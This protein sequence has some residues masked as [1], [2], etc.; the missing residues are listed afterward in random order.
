MNSILGK[1]HYIRYLIKV[2][3]EKNLIYLPPDM[4]NDFSKPALL[5]FLLKHP[6]SILIIEDA[7]NIVRDR[8]DLKFNPTQAV[9]NL[10]N[11]SDGLLN[12][13]LSMQIIATFNC[14]LSSIDQALLRPGRLIAIHAFDRLPIDN[15]KRLSKSLDLGEDHVTTPMTLAEIYN[16][17]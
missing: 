7:E 6:N 5:T 17:F 1:T 8:T 2:I 11:L 15:A 9:A 13:A 16:C 12:D 4:A 3:K 10:L 14:E